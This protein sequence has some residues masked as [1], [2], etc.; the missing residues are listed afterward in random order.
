MERIFSV[1][2]KDCFDPAAYFFYFSL[3]KALHLY[4]QAKNTLEKEIRVA[5]R[6][7]F[8]KLRI[9]FSSSDSASVWKINPPHFY[10]IK[11]LYEQYFI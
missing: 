1:S 5:K 8:D 4:K 10:Q 11:M 9:P 6:N 7:Y 3:D 2:Y